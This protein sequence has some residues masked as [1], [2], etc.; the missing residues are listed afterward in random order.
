M[1]KL[2]KKLW[3][4]AEKLFERMV[5]DF[6]KTAGGELYYGLVRPYV[7]TLARSGKKEQAMDAIDFLKKRNVLD[8]GPGSI[9]GLE[10]QTLLQKIN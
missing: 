5:K 7:E 2:E 3:V 4:D 10:M 6:E 8:L 9:I 1:N